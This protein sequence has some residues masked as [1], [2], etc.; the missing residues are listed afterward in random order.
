MTSRVDI[1]VQFYLTVCCWLRNGHGELRNSEGEVVVPAGPRV[2]N[3]PG[4]ARWSSIR[5]CFIVVDR[6]IRIGLCRGRTDGRDIRAHPERRSGRALISCNEHIAS[7]AS[8]Q[9]D[10]RSLVGVLSG[11]QFTVSEVEIDKTHNGNKVIGND[12]QLMA[13]NAETLKALR[14]RID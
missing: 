5:V 14:T 8:G 1:V 2:W 10:N 6:S 3:I 13:I 12:G 11:G 4:A 9:R 7:L